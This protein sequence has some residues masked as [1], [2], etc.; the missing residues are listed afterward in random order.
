MADEEHRLFEYVVYVGMSPEA[1]R[2]TS[3]FLNGPPVLEIDYPASVCARFP[4]QDRSHYDFPRTIADF[5]FPTGIKIFINPPPPRFHTFVLTNLNGM[6][7]YG[8]CCQISHLLPIAQLSVFKQLFGAQIYTNMAYSEMDELPELFFGDECLIVLS[9]HP[10]HRVYEQLMVAFCNT[11]DPYAVF[12][13]QT[14]IDLSN[15]LEAANCASEIRVGD[16]TISLAPSQFSDRINLPPL[17]SLM[18]CLDPS[19]VIQLFTLLI[20]EQS[21][22]FVSDDIALL[23]ACA[24]AALALLF[25]LEWPY[26]YIPLLPLTLLD[27]YDAPMP[28]LVGVPRLS[29]KDRMPPEHAAI[30]DL[31]RNE[32][33]AAKG[34]HTQLTHLPSRHVSRLWD[35]IQKYANLFAYH[36]PELPPRR[37][38][39]LA[40][41]SQTGRVARGRANVMTIKTLSA[42]YSSSSG[43]D[44]SDD[45]SCDSHDTPN[46][47]PRAS[48]RTAPMPSSLRPRRRTRP[49]AFQ[50]ASSPL[51]GMQIPIVHVHIVVNNSETDEADEQPMVILNL[52][53]EMTSALGSP[54]ST[55]SWSSPSTVHSSPVAYAD[56]AGAGHMNHAIVASA[57]TPIPRPQYTA[58][59]TMSAPQILRTLSSPS[60]PTADTS[61]QAVLR[62]L[63]SSSNVAA[64]TEPA[65]HSEMLFKAF[66]R[67]WVSLLKGYRPFLILPSAE[68]PNPMDLFDRS[69]FLAECAEDTQDILRKFISTQM[70]SCFV[71]D[72]IT[73]RN[74]GEDDL[75]RR[76]RIKNH[77]RVAK[78][79]LLANY[80]KK[81]GLFKQCYVIKIWKRRVISLSGNELREYKRSGEELEEQGCMR[82]E[83]G[84]TRVIVSTDSRKTPTE[85]PFEVHC[86]SHSFVL[87]AEDS[88]TRREWIRIIKAKTS[89][90]LLQKPIDANPAFVESVARQREQRRMTVARYTMDFTRR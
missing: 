52:A 59:S 12:T 1:L 11:L 17:R 69:A 47:S 51:L 88:R 85:F 57:P 61:T 8:Y 40:G 16:A 9:C 31:D 15:L 74:S 62:H 42:L 19:N 66:S 81:G 39:S 3:S 71:Q 48:F 44:N 64:L 45:E 7:V 18:R 28:F 75:D 53:V 58:Q 76:V 73:H 82:L 20:N 46:M 25:P 68:D 43:S 14:I 49:L 50:S 63:N 72:R 60:T 86:G 27:V 24:E 70:F 29:L 10:L 22:V 5:A 56:A 67:M 77:R 87:C 23:T 80:N 84:K 55:A 6:R 37:P 83:S 26:A 89:L 33:A 21:I 35:A 65:I 34:K 30:V 4:V 13:E 38:A 32:I 41:V 54:Y 78:L 36:H 90:E 2:K 79:Q